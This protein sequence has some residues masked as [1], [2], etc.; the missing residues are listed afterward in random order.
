MAV[1]INEV[2]IELTVLPD[3]AQGK[4]SDTLDIDGERRILYLG[5]NWT[6]GL[7]V[8]D[9]A[10]GTPR[11]VR[12]IKLRGRIYGVAVAGDLEKVFAGMSGSTLAAISVGGEKSA[13]ELIDTGGLGHVDLIDYD[14]ANRRVFAANRLDGLMTCI[15]AVSHKVTGRVTGLGRGL[16]Q[17]RFNP[18][19]GMVYLTDNVENVLF[20]IDPETS[21]LKETYPIAAPC[22]PNGMA[23]NPKTNQAVLA[24]STHDRPATVVWDLGRQEI[25]TVVEDCGG[26]DGVVYDPA[27]DRFLVA[28]SG[29]AGGPVIGVFGGDPVRM[30]AKIPTAK[31]SSWVGFD[32]RT[33]Q[34]YA[35]AVEQGRPALLHFKLPGA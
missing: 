28:A 12:T 7:D 4:F 8:F 35:P 25:V 5:D 20:K 14:Q 18:A 26:A 3:S 29:S 32:S 16:E 6:G 9:I 2:P 22:F 19:D 24:C 23:I 13:V 21:T 15:D 17:P 10:A 33:R 27:L 31:G 34:V 11:Y 30:Q 1:L